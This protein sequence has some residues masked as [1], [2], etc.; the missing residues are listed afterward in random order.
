MSKHIIAICNQKGGVGKT[1]TSLELAYLFG[2]KHKTLLIDMDAQRNASLYSG[3]NLSHNGIYELLNAKCSIA[4]ATQRIQ[5]QDSCFDIIISN[6]KMADASKEFGEPDDIFLLS[7]IVNALDYDIILLDQ[8]PARSPLLYMS[9]NASTDF[10]IIAECDKG[11]LEGIQEIHADIQRFVNRGLCKGKILGLLL[12]KYEN[13]IMHKAA[14][15]RLQN[16]GK[17]QLNVDTFHTTIRKTIA[18]SECKEVSKCINQYD[19]WNNAAVDYR[20]LVKEILTKWGK[21]A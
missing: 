21:E 5:S 12:T 16:I 11:S 7:D 2:Q 20:Q 1:T 13:T 9:Y 14:Y 15:E 10:V 3:A 8:A 18:V 6:R 19:K 4:E 17:T